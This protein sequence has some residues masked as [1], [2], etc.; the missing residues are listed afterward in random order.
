MINSINQF[1]PIDGFIY[2]TA[3]GNYVAQIANASDTV[4]DRHK[5][6]RFD[7]ELINPNHPQ[8]P[9]RRLAVIAAPA[10]LER[11]RSAFFRHINSWAFR[12]QDEDDF[13]AS[14]WVFDSIA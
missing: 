1:L 14:E 8:F 9:V 10:A 4:V 2:Q 7:I 11:H 12:H 6:H 3:Y 5:Q 13:L